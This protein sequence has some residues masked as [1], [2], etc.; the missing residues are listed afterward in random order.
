M[1]AF[2]RGETLLLHHRYPRKLLGEIQYDDYGNVVYDEEIFTVRGAVVW[3]QTAAE[4]RQSQERTSMT[5]FVAL[6]DGID[7]DAV[8][9]VVWRGKSYE[10]QGELEMNTNPAT[11][12][13]CNTFVMN[14]VEG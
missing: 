14:R 10:V 6:P 7:V 5:Y 13:K 8:D 1:H 11:G 2:E 4:V 12:T 3:P 9:R